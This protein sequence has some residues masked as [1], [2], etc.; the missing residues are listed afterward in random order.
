MT[1]GGAAW[2]DAEMIG[3]GDDDDVVRWGERL[4]QWRDDQCWSQ[5][6]LVDRIVR[7]AYA[8]REDRGT[9]LD[10]R[11][12]GKWESGQVRCPQAVY[13]RLLA[14]LGAPVP[15]ERDR[16][17]RQ[18]PG[19]AGGGLRSGRIDPAVVRM[20]AGRV[21][22]VAARYEAELSATLLA[23]AAQ[24]HAALT[25]LLECS[26]TEVARRQL[27]AA[28]TLS[29]ALLGQLV[30]DAS[31]RRHGAAAA[32]YCDLAAE[33]A[34]LCGDMVS[35]ANA[36][37]RKAYVS[38]YGPVAER[39]PQRGLAM[40]LAAARRSR[41]ISHALHGVAQLHVGEAFG[42]LGEYRQC[43]QAL[44]AAEAAFDAMGSD[45]V[46]GQMYSPAQFG[47]LAGSCYL[48]LGHPERAESLL[49]GTLGLLDERRKT[50]SLV[51]GNLA[52]SHIR[53]RR[54]DAATA[55]LHEAIA[56]LEQAR[57]GG[58]MSVVFAAA[59]ELYP[60]RAEPAVQDL[61]DRLL[62]LVS[63]T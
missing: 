43:E 56:L 57:G 52:T 36:E 41:G 61:H 5:Q 22:E 27:H 42:V 48:S 39:N 54:L 10:V 24:H 28:L 18:T 46:A 9:R 32:A 51:L 8:T 63:R 4:R 29:A 31:G 58:G 7:L 30:W 59:R 23:E 44:G 45:D 38:L 62:G 25:G 55:T 13:R 53:Q 21:D 16:R 47:R 49:T 2:E 37:L 17:S 20:L 15:D 34:A 1:P 6:E 26:G 50:K 14:Q 11:L 35:T 40:S 33:H 12:V 19:D 3:G 60:W